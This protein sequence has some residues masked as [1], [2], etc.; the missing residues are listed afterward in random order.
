MLQQTQTER[1]REYYRRFLHE[2]P[3]FHALSNASFGDVLR[4][5]QGLGYN[6]RALALKNA[7]IEVMKTFQGKLPSDEES[8]ISLPGIGKYTARA[9][10]AFAF[11]EPTVLLE[12]NIRTVYL[13]H[14]FSTRRKVS[15][16]EIE[17]VIAQT[18]YKKDP[19]AW[20]Y[21]LMDYGVLLK[22][23]APSVNRKSAHYRQQSKFK[24]SR[25]ELRGKIVKM[26]LSQ[27]ECSI[28]LLLRG[29]KED[30]A[31]FHEIL[32]ALEREGFLDRL[33]NKVRLRS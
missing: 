33:P 21:A 25:R 9:V 13:T 4:L 18:V 11:N 14:F 8:L 3:D 27:K 32:S 12:T 5:W 16:K 26:L 10:Q 28:R 24:G 31:R 22:K 29:L 17:Q 30:P 15:D 7:A 6:R 20:Y 19:R 1:V 23:S 2:L